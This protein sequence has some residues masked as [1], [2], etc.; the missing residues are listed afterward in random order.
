MVS[1]RGLRRNYGE[2]A[3]L[4]GLG[5]DVGRNEVFGIIGPDGAGKTSLFRILATLLLPDGGS[6]TVDGLD[7]AKDYSAIRSRIGYMPGRFSLYQD[8]SV[9]ENLEF[10]ATVFNT[11]IEENYGLIADIYERLEPFKKRRA[12]AL[13]GG[14][15]QKLALCCA[16][17]H[18]PTVL[19]LDEPTTGVDPVSRKEFWDMLGRLR[20]QGI[21]ILVSTPYMDEA[22]LCDRIALMQGGSFLDIDTPAGIVGKYGKDLL[23]VRGLRMAKLLADL[24]AHAKV[25]SCYAFGDAHHVS[26]EKGSLSVEELRRYLGSMGHEGVAIES[27]EPGVEDCFMDLASPEGGA[28]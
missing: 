28:A 16:L 14:M 11:T 5:F 19:F 17:I 23:A 1:A 26:M 21:T 20:D 4:K 10:F 22:G 9:E 7:V 2:V 12:G 6:A 3:A 15:K 25:T 27:I 8:L 24:R 13:S 18:R